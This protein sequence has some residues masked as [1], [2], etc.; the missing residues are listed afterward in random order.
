MPHRRKG[1]NEFSPKL[2]FEPSQSFLYLSCFE[3]GED[4]LCVPMDTL[5][6]IF[7]LQFC[8]IKNIRIRFLLSPV[9]G[10]SVK[11]TKSLDLQYNVE[12]RGETPEQVL[13]CRLP[14]WFLPNQRTCIAG[15]CSVVRYAFRLA[16]FSEQLELCKTLLGFQQGCLSAPQEVSTWTK[17]CEVDIHEPL[18]DLSCDKLETLPEAISKFEAHLKQPVRMHNIRDK[19]QKSG[20]VN[21][22]LENGVEVMIENGEKVDPIEVYARTEHVFA[23]GPEMLVSDVLIFPIFY[24]LNLK[25]KLLHKYPHI[26]TW[27]ENVSATNAISVMEKL[28]VEIEDDLR[29]IALLPATVP[30]ESL[31][32]CDPN[33]SK[34]SAKL[35]TRQGDID[36]AMVWWEESGIPSMQEYQVAGYEQLVWEDLPRLVHPLAGSLPPDRLERKCGQLSSL[37]VPLARLAKPGNIL[38]DFCSGGGHLGLLVAHLAPSS[39]VHMVE[40]KEESLARARQRGVEMQADNVWFFQCNLEYYIGSFNIGSSLHACGVATDLVIMKCT[41][42]RAAFV[43]CPC[44]YGGVQCLDTIT[45]PR[46]RLY[47]EAGLGLESYLVLAHAA[48]QTQPGVEK[49]EQGKL[50]MDIVDTDRALGVRELGYSVTLSKLEP[51]D[52]TPKNNL[53]IGTPPSNF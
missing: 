6:I 28:V 13:A 20:K 7:S 15:L 44:C 33:R 2:Q 38:V 23:E 25:Y 16:H 1:K 37:A 17:F 43:C 39:T 18:E 50:C 30:E 8:E 9:K 52:C 4:F 26:Q 34:Q 46:S 45:Y 5:V 14:A 41:Q 3:E 21:P 40:N 53:L 10:V 49:C 29:F 22:V 48:D 12:T 35:Y 31:Y 51:R 24:M 32:K 11:I 42:A 47:T 27:Y 36:T 19:M